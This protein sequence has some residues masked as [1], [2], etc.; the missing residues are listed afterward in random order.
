MEIPEEFLK[1]RVYKLSELCEKWDKT[2]DELLVFIETTMLIA[3][4]WYDGYGFKVDEKPYADDKELYS[5]CNMQWRG[6]AYAYGSIASQL[7]VYGQASS[8]DYIR[9]CTFPFFPGIDKTTPGFIPAEKLDIDGT[10]A[11]KTKKQTIT[12]HELVVSFNEVI[13]F[14]KTFPEL[15]QK[16]EIVT[17]DEIPQY[18][19][20]N[21]K[22]HAPKL[23]AA[24]AAWESVSSKPIPRNSKSPKE[25]LTN[26]LKNNTDKHVKAL[27]L[28][29]GKPNNQA[30]DEIAKIA[31][32]QFSGPK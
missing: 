24:I 27:L 13:N 31:N 18:L 10:I 28:P 16:S 11:W 8:T 29:D 7:R 5:D 3:L 19:N 21:L 26:W 32:W 17:S 2:E 6:W 4:F 22:T 12:V 15:T 25:A 1:N 30:I 14:E 23:A 20:T 9:G